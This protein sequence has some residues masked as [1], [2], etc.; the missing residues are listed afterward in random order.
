[1]FPHPNVHKYAWTFPD[2]KT[3]N[4]IDHMLL[5]RKRS[6]IFDVQS[7][8]TADCDTGHYLLVAKFLE[9]LEVNK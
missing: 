1:M 9:R 4:Q 8:M 3:Y 6:S 7:S 5:G 2:G